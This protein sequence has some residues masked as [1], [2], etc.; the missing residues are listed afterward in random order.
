MADVAKGSVLLTPKFD[1]LMGTINQELN[2]ALSSVSSTATKSGSNAASSFSGGFSAKVGGIMGV[3][4]TIASGAFSAISNSM[5]AAISRA[6]TLNNYPKVM[7]N[8]GYSAED[9]SASISKISSSLDGLPSSTDSVASMV[10]QLAPLTSGLDEATDLGLALNNMMLASGASTADVSRAMQQYTQILSKGVPDMQDWKTLQ[11]VMPGQLNQVAQSLLGAGA[12]SN[13]LYNALKDGTLTMDDFNAAVMDLNTNG[14]DG[15]ASFEQQARDATQGIGTA[16]ENVQTRITRALTSIIEC[17][18]VENISGAINAFSSS[19]SVI[20]DVVI[21]II[22]QIKPVIAEI[23]NYFTSGSSGISQALTTIMPA[24]S[25]ICN[26]VGSVLATALQVCW[27]TLEPVITAVLP[28][29]VVVIQTIISVVQGLLEVLNGVLSFVAGVF[30][31]NWEQAWSGVQQIADGI[32]NTISSLISGSINFV[33]SIITGVLSTIAGIW[34]SAWSAISSLAISIWNGISAGIDTIINGIQAVISLVLGVISSVWNSIWN[35][36]STFVLGIWSTIQN[37]VDTAIN[38]VS[39]VIDSVLSTISSVW[40][41]VWSSISGFFSGIWEG[42]KSAASDGISAVFDTVCG[43]KDSICDF[44]ANAGTWLLDSGRAILQGLIDG[45]TSAIGGAIDAVSGAVG[46]IRN[47]FPFSPAKEGP[48]SGHGYT[49]YSGKALITDFGKS[50]EEYAPRA[51]SAIS[52][53]LGDIQDL[54]AQEMTFA[55]KA[56]IS[57]TYRASLNES[58]SKNSNAREVTNWLAQN[59]PAI[60]AA[61]TPTISERDF[62]RKTRKAVAYG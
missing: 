42:L 14:L 11:E 12:S 40:N 7:Q 53:A 17:I 50:V 27:A 28:A 47:L 31:G 43:I 61:Y 55:A 13:D 24:L 26:L 25:E 58:N 29:A 1:N 10:Q 32:W 41:S 39:S 44:F 52:N 51:Q 20:A 3:A 60:I 9:A 38:A 45:I 19:F 62:A 2:S 34:S 30:T 54:T 48:F 4:S 5:T 35:T 22:E 33:L 37:S 36:I 6:D 59:L 18:G 8:L 46:Q 57:S 56:D 15:F 23:F 16:I 49:T 21:G